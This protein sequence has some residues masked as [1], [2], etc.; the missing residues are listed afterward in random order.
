MPDP[1]SP[2]IKSV[3]PF[4]AQGTHLSFIG[5]VISN[6]DVM[7]DPRF[8]VEQA[9]SMGVDESVLSCVVQ[10]ME[11][12]T[13]DQRVKELMRFASNLGLSALQTANE[14]ERAMKEANLPRAIGPYQL[15]KQW[16]GLLFVSGQLGLSPETGQLVEGGTVEQTRQAMDNLR[17]ILD[18]HDSGFESVIKTTVYLTDIDDFDAM[19]MA[20]ANFLRPDYPARSTIGVKGLPRGARVEIDAIASVRGK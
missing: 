4:V 8:L 5:R 13:K 3:S 19:N 15:A 11:R 2:A 18:Y 7:M 14:A 17:R 12:P 1:I 9:R 10:I 16:N 6:L 20:Y